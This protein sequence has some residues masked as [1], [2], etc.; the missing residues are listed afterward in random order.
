MPDQL[1]PVVMNITTVNGVKYKTTKRFI[2]M[3]D[4]VL[5]EAWSLD[6]PIEQWT[7]CERVEEK[8]DDA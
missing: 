6:T 7:V 5:Y 4:G 3:R 1:G 2:T 8:K